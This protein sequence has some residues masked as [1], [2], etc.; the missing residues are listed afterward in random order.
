MVDRYQLVVAAVAVGVGA[1]IALLDHWAR[2]VARPD[3]FTAAAVTR[4]WA[5]AGLSGALIGG[6]LSPRTVPW[7]VAASIVVVVPDRPSSPHPLGRLAPVLCLVSLA[8]VWSA[9]PDTEAAV[10]MGA[11]LAPL[12]ASHLRRGPSPGPAGTAALVVGVLGAVWVGSAGRGAALTAVAAVGMLLIAPAVLGWGELPPGRDRTAV[13]VSHV[14]VALVLPR[15]VMERPAPVAAGAAVALSAVL[16]GVA[17]LV[18]RGRD[19]RAAAVRRS[20]G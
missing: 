14:A 16:V 17:A 6:W 15:A 20:P 9:V 1:L 19:G 8:G 3:A 4:V 5:V 18:R 13:V 11:V 10:A 7:W 12:A 2:V